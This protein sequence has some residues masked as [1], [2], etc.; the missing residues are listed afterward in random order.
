MKKIR[1]VILNLLKLSFPTVAPLALPEP[2]HS[3]IKRCHLLALPFNLGRTLL[4]L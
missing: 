1:G 3:L 2:Y 4:Q